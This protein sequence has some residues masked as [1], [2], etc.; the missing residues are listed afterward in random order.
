[1]HRVLPFLAFCAILMAGCVSDHHHHPPGYDETDEAFDR[2]FE[3][4]TDGSGNGSGA[5]GPDQP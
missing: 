2:Y 3:E 4:R 1:M 5:P